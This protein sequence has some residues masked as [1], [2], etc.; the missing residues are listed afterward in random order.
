MKLKKINLLIIL[1]VTSLLL[2]AG[3]CS[4]KNPDFSTSRNVKIYLVPI[5]GETCVFD[6]S[7]NGL[8]IHLEIKSS[9]GETKSE[10][11]YT[12]S[13]I[14]SDGNGNYIETNKV[15]KDGYFG[16]TVTVIASCNSCCS[17][18]GNLTARPIYTGAASDADVQSKSYFIRLRKLT[19][20]DGCN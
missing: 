4:P 5:I 19:C 3:G 15:P 7:D 20:V 8:E 12:K 10:E 11:S 14:K 6:P 18:S 9:S 1:A 16:M 2:T 13:A 17:P